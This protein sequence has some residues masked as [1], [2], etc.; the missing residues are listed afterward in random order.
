[1]NN[2]II[3]D[4]FFCLYAAYLVIKKC[5][6]PVILIIVGKIF[7]KKNKSISLG[8]G[9]LGIIWLLYIVLTMIKFSI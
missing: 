2:D 4:L 7:Y 8:I 5:I 6:I 9:F 1:M 3:L